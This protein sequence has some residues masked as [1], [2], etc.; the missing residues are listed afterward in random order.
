[1]DVYDRFPSQSCQ[2]S[3]IKE[4]GI[5]DIICYP[6]GGRQCTASLRYFLNTFH[7]VR[8]ITQEVQ[9]VL[10]YRDGWYMQV[11]IPSVVFFIGHLPHHQRH[12]WRTRPASNKKRMTDYI[13][14][15]HTSI[16]I[17]QISFHDHL[18]LLVVLNKHKKNGK[19]HYKD[20]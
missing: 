3:L 13:E 7:T 10:C 19:L 15:P 16:F 14:K 12:T 4:R 5:K 6:K 17:G 1:M 2:T 20:Q 9:N 11:H 18:I 8:F